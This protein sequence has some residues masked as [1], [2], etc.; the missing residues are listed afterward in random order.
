[1]GENRRYIH[2]GD[3]K[4]GK[5]GGLLAVQN[6]RRRGHVPSEELSKVKGPETGRPSEGVYAM[7]GDANPR[8]MRK[9][10]AKKIGQNFGNWSMA[11][12]GGLTVPTLW[13]RKIVLKIFS[14]LR[15]KNRKVSG[16][17]GEEGDVDIEE[18]KERV[19]RSPGARPMVVRC[20]ER[21][22]HGTRKRAQSK[23]RRGQVE[24]K[25]SD[26]NDLAGK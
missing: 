1:M 3:P 26:A 17:G 10:G 11:I 25:Y 2:K 23:P 22:G 15:T 9:L 20:W 21:G 6:C 5:R 12:P 18:G 4:V 8:E 7:G 14:K 13:L 24:P 19:R 16:Q